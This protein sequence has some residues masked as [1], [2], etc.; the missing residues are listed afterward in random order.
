ML[1]NLQYNGV[2]HERVLLLTVQSRECAAYRRSERLYLEPLGTGLYR[3]SLRFG[4][5]EE[6]D[7]PLALR[8]LP[9]HG[10]AFEPD[11]VPYFVSR[12]LVIPPRCPA[13]RCGASA[14]IVSYV[15]IRPARWTFFAWRRARCSR[16]LLP[17]R[18]SLE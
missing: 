9:A 16:S 10:F 13:W 14:C 11:E 7:V 2:V 3:C 4:F 1:A 6:P 17:S 5:M 15:T 18:F 12:T 8:A